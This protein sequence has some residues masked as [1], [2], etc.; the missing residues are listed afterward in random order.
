MAPS[1]GHDCDGID[2]DREA[3]GRAVARRWFGREPW[4]YTGSSVARTGV[5]DDIPRR[6]ND[7]DR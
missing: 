6:R 4:S 1:P 7:I 5:R 2:V 3:A